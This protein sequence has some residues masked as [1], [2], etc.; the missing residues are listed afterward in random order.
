MNEWAENVS[1]AF[2]K[3]ESVWHV[4][5]VKIELAEIDARNDSDSRVTIE[6][7]VEEKLKEIQCV[8]SLD[9]E[10]RVYDHD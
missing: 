7:V 3:S 4:F 10:H 1:K 2:E 5:T 8:R 6:E 9:I